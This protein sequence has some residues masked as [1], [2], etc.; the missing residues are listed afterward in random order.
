MHKVP[1]TQQAPYVIACLPDT[2]EPATLK[3]SLEAGRLGETLPPPLLSRVI[4][5]EPHLPEPPSYKAE[6][7]LSS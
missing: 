6:V 4:L 5:G 2:H 1:D 3:P 7:N